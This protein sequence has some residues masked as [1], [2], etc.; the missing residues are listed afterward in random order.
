MCSRP[1][2][3]GCWLSSRAWVRRWGTV[4]AH[5]QR[6]WM[7]HAHPRRPGSGC[8]VEGLTSGT[9]VSFSAS[10]FPSTCLRHPCVCFGKHGCSGG[11]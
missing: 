7:V 5:L 3:A 1:H 8:T 10:A 6:P 4:T 11:V 2:T 9:F